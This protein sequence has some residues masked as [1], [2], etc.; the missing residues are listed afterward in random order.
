MPVVLPLKP[1][2]VQRLVTIEGLMVH[3]NCSHQRLY[4]HRAT[5]EARVSHGKL[6][7][8]LHFSERWIRNI[9]RCCGK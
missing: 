2:R 7:I 8:A 9:Q 1:Q 5:E 6:Q 4:M 3:L